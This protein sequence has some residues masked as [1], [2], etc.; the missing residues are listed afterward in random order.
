M[1]KPTIRIVH[2]LNQFFGGIGGEDKADMG[3]RVVPGPAG[4]GIGLQREFGDRAQIVA[5]LTCGDNYA[6]L[7][8]DA[9][10]REVIAAA[11]EYSPN[12]FVAGPAFN[13]GRYGVACGEMCKSVAAE[14]GIPAVTAMYFEN[15]G[16]GIYKAA[17][18]IWILPTDELAAGMGKVLPTLAAFILKLGRRET[19]GPA[20][21]EGYIPTGR[22]VLGFA[23]KPGAQ[24]AIE[25]LLA[26]LNNQP[27]TTEIPLELFSPVRP[28]PPVAD[29]RH[30]RLA[31]ITTSGMVPRGNPDDFKMFNASSWRTY[32]LPADSTLRPEDWE[33]IHGGFNTAFA[34]ANPNVVLPLDALLEFSGNKYGEL[35]PRFYSMTG[36]GTSLSVAK[37]VGEEIAAS[38]REAQIDAVLL[39]AT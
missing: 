9:A 7:E 23:S 20:G 34:Q 15:P 21:E 6:N 39:V 30:A 22:R 16:V 18:N 17:P 2:Y 5:T 11:R 31:V 33:F 25:M 35:Y 14:L 10:R 4:P 36:V 1:D 24:R 29:L 3:L 37:R 38:L 12:V 13:A 19:P 27:F 32:P 8:M 26:K 28:A